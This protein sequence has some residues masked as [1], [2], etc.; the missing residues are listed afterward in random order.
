MVWNDVKS[1]LNAEI[2]IGR[3]LTEVEGMF[4]LI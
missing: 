1:E 2:E 4:D 3:E